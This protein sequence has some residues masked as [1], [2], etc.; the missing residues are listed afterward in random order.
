MG[1]MCSEPKEEK[2]NTELECKRNEII[3]SQGPLIEKCEFKYNY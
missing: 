2:E 3:K 1:S